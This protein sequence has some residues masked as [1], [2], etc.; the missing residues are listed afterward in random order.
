MNCRN[1]LTMSLLILTF[2][3]CAKKDALEDR[4]EKA[5]FLGSEIDSENK[6][7]SNLYTENKKV[8]YKNGVFQ[9]TYDPYEELLGVKLNTEKCPLQTGTFSAKAKC[10][11]IPPA[12][13][14]EDNNSNLSKKEFQQLT[15]DLANPIIEKICYTEECIISCNKEL[16]ISKLL[17]LS[18]KTKPVN[19]RALNSLRDKD[20]A[21]ETIT[22]IV[23]LLI[24]LIISFVL[25][26]YVKRNMLKNF[27]N[28]KEL[29]TIRTDVTRKSK[30]KDGVIEFNEQTFDSYKDTPCQNI[31][32]IEFMMDYPQKAISKYLFAIPVLIVVFALMFLG[33][34]FPKIATL[35]FVAII[36]LTIVLIRKRN[37]Y[38]IKK[39]ATYSKIDQSL[40]LLRVFNSEK[41]TD[42]LFS[43][44]EKYWNAVAN[45]F[46]IVD[47]YLVKYDF[48]GKGGRTGIL[49]A[50]LIVFL[51]IAMVLF[52]IFDIDL[53]LLYAIDFLFP[54]INPNIYPWIY[55]TSLFIIFLFPTIL[56]M[57]IYIDYIFIKNSEDLTKKIQKLTRS[58]RY[59]CYDNMWKETISKTVSLV[60]VVVMDLRGFSRER[61]GCEYEI[62][63]LLNNFSFDKTIF[64][65]DETTDFIFL[66]EV[67]NKSLESIE[68]TS[69]NFSKK[70]KNIQC[71]T[72]KTTVDKEE[73]D[74]RQL[75]KFLLN[76]HYE[77]TGKNE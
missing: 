11:T 35:L 73:L 66:K 21:F 77:Y 39:A 44:F 14:A 31:E 46:T 1:I 30:K 28:L 6:T 71:N 52:S 42:F 60:S 74:A 49:R 58:N 29:I 13:L 38:I 27:K 3:G 19:S 68:D 18:Q 24:F 8:F 70:E 36:I 45:T 48:S 25:P 63:Y 65:I 10:I 61:S 17:P 40:L 41:I 69:P 33:N 7:C 59:Y 72:Y 62:K 2:I 76:L 50:N 67:M 15:H 57:K 16:N 34:I 75:C 53:Y 43:R 54:N 4:I 37:L 64:V 20:K 55:A 23:E 26:I 47:P 56:F 22:R 51:F 32:E 12:P 9:P 5:I